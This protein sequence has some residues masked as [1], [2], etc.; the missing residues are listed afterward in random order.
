M[1]QTE[2]EFSWDGLVIWARKQRLVHLYAGVGNQGAAGQDRQA[3]G[4]GE[5]DSRGEIVHVSGK[6]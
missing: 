6:K 5:G 3:A 4:E 2:A 1:E